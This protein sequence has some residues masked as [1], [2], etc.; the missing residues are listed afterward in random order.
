MTAPAKLGVRAAGA[1]GSDAI[2]ARV[3]GT[4][5]PIDAR[6]PGAMNEVWPI[7]EFTYLDPATC[8]G[9]NWADRKPRIDRYWSQLDPDYVD[10]EGAESLVGFVL[11]AAVIAIF[12]PGDILQALGATDVIDRAELSAPGKPLQKERWAAVVDAVGSH[13][14][15]NVCAQTKYR[16]VVAACGLAQ[17]MD[18]PSS[19]A[20]FIL[21]GVSL[22]GI[23]SVMAPKSERMQ[24][25]SRLASD[26]DAG[27][28]N[29]MTAEIGLAQAIEQAPQILAGKVRGRLVVNVDA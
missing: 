4:A 1:L 27:K 6:F 8:V 15:A 14:L 29:A 12:M 3:V 22:I 10:G 7:Q 24:A 21:R 26:L 2:E 11:A 5:R 9:T 16:G 17:G 25:W 20:P 13:T 19:V 18:F 23:D 28:L